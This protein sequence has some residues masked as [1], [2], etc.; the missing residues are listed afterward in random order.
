MQPRP[1]VTFKETVSQRCNSPSWQA[2]T[3][4]LHVQC[5]FLFFIIVVITIIIKI[6][7]II[8]IIS[9]LF[10]GGFPEST[11]PDIVMSARKEHT[12]KAHYFIKLLQISSVMLYQICPE[13]IWNFVTI[14][15][16]LGGVEEWPL[17]CHFKCSFNNLVAF[18]HRSHIH[19]ILAAK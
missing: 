15:L 2:A 6:I 1:A 19:I 13:E 18:T 10:H 5:F 17:A 4:T 14:P 11:I 12:V 8:I 16:Y 3:I 7:I 9:S